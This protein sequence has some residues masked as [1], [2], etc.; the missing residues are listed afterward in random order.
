MN[1]PAKNK[2]QENHD[3]SRG[4]NPIITPPAVLIE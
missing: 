4:L 1:Q 3:I 2:V